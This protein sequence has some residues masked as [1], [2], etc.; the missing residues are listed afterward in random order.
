MIVLLL[1]SLFFFVPQSYAVSDTIAMQGVKWDHSP[2]TVFIESK[3]RA[4]PN[5]VFEAHVV[6]AFTDWL[7]PLG[8]NYQVTFLTA[9]D[10]K[11]RPA[12]IHVQLKKNTG[13]SLGVT[14]TDASGGTISDIKIQ[15]ATQNALGIALDE[16]DFR[17]IARHEIGH[18]WGV[19]HTT[20]DDLVAPIDLMHPSFDF[21]ENTGDIKP[22]QCNVAGSPQGPDVDA[23]LHLYQSDGFGV[24]NVGTIPSTFSCS[25]GPGGGNGGNGGPLTVSI[26]TDSATY[27]PGDF[28]FI[29]VEVEDAGT[30]VDAHVVVRIESPSGKVWGWEGNI[31]SDG[32]VTI[33]HKIKGND[34]G[35]NTVTAEADLN[36]GTGQAIPITY[37]VV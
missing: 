3:G 28:A 32:E 35:T 6:T 2:V 22:S 20:D 31:G 10:S 30:P 37:E 5:G 8:A 25:G 18:A 12:D 24:P 13:T 11:R 27:S 23:V 4:D 7:T 19:G 34:R 15:L 16:A 1:G 29:T 21:V 33:R 9:P 17:T 14:F 36:G 26:T